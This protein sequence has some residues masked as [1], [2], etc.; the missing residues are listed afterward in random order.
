MS[1]P[2]RTITDTGGAS[3]LVMP[4][5]SR[6]RLPASGGGGGAPSGPAGGDLSGTYPNPAVVDDSHAHTG[7][8]ISALDA[9]DTTTGTFA[10]ARIPTGTSAATVALG[11][12]A[13]D[14]TY[15]RVGGAFGTAVRTGNVTLTSGV[16]TGVTGWAAEASVPGAGTGWA[17]PTIGSSGITVSDQGL[18]LVKAALTICSVGSGGV[19]GN[20][21]VVEPTIGGN[22]IT[23]QSGEKFYIPQ[24]NSPE[25]AG[26]WLVPITATSVISVRV[27]AIGTGTLNF[28]GGRLIVAGPVN[29][30]GT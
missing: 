23:G 1:N 16:F 28:G 15:A 25:I 29:R 7:A 21:Y 14:G 13:H 6:V 19:A 20:E 27:R 2:T 11:N 10:L 12:H 4:D 3:W 9:G 30:I 24:A 26:V 8:T 22:P 5:G 18:Y 17:A